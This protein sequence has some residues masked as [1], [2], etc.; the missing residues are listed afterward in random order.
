MIIGIYGS[1]VRSEQR[2]TSDTNILV[3]IERP[4]GFKFFEL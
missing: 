4:I 1:Y 3:E 2:E